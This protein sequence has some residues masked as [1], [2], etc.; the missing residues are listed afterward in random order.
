MKKSPNT[1]LEANDLGHREKDAPGETVYFCCN[2]AFMK[3]AVYASTLDFS[4]YMEGAT[5]ARC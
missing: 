4:D 2:S 1:Q 5:E 3:S